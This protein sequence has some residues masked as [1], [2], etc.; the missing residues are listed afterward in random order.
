MKIEITKDKNKK[1][2]GYKLIP[3]TTHEKYQIN[4]LRNWY[5]FQKVEYD[6]REKGCSKFAGNLK[7]KFVE[8]L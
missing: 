2:I 5:F 8:V 4:E 6:G 7:F 1:T 3:E